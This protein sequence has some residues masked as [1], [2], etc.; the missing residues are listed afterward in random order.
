MMLWHKVIKELM[1]HT[2]LQMMNGASQSDSIVF[3]PFLHD[4]DDVLN[5]WIPSAA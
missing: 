3:A 2:L 4:A 5:L 1:L